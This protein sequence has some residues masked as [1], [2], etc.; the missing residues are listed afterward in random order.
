MS[1]GSSTDRGAGG[2]ATSETT[3]FSGSQ[4]PSPEPPKPTIGD[5]GSS[6]ATAY[7]LLRKIGEGGMG[8]V[9]EAEQTRPVRRRLAVK[10]IKR[11]MDTEGVVRRFEAERQALALMDHPGIAKVFDAGATERGRPFFAMELVRGEPITEYCDKNRLDLDARLRLFC[12]VCDAVQHAHQKAVIHRD[13]KPSNV[14]VSDQGGVPAPKI[15]DFGV[16]KATTQP[17]TE[18]TLYTQIGQVIGTP[19][20]MSPE[21]AEMSSADID[22]RS[23]VYSLGVILYVLMTGLLPFDAHRLHSVSIDEMRRI[24]RDE[25]PPT[26]S[27]MLRR[28]RSSSTTTGDRRAG[29]ERLPRELAG[30][31]D[32]IVMKALE[33]DRARRYG[34]AREFAA[35]IE[36]HLEHIPVLARPITVRYRMAKFVRRHWGGVLIGSSLLFALIAFATFSGYQAKRIATERDRAN[37]QAAIA[38]QVSRFLI[39]LFEVS[40]PNLAKGED[41]TARELL[42][43]GA[44]RIETELGDQPVVRAKLQ[45]TI[46]AVYESVGRFDRAIEMLRA[47]AAEQRRLLGSRHEETL[48]TLAALS[49][50]LYREGRYSEQEPIEF[51]LLEARIAKHGKA[52]VTVID[53]LNGVGSLRFDQGRT[54]EA[55]T[56][57]EQAAELT[58]S[59]HGT[60]SRQ[61]SDA[62]YNLGMINWQRGD[63][64]SAVSRMREAVRLG[65]ASLGRD[66]RTTITARSTLGVMLVESGQLPEAE[67]LLRQALADRRRMLGE[68]HDGTLISVGY[69]H[70]LQ[71]E[72]GRFEEALTGLE[73][74]IETRLRVSPPTHP[75]TVAAFR[76]AAG[77]LTRME[78]VE[79]AESLLE[80]A[81]RQD[82]RLFS[83][84][85]PGML[86]IRL[87][88]AKLMLV[89]KEYEAAR[90]A[91]VALAET[92]VTR[93]D[94]RMEFAN[95]LI[96]QAEALLALQRPDEAMEA[97]DRAKTLLAGRLQPGHPLPAEIDGLLGTTLLAKGDL[98]AARTL[99]IDSHNR[100]AAISGLDP[101]KVAAA[102]RRVA[103]FHAARGEEGEAEAW[104]QR[105]ATAAP[106]NTRCEKAAPLL[107]LTGRWSRS[108][109]DGEAAASPAG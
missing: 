57:Y 36:R 78:C 70:W 100:L 10:V 26:P 80:A 84:D 86:A 96:L 15:I 2:P 103:A 12:R 13:L 109:G 82:A 64:V 108:L 7:K 101:R 87:D 45:A 79:E 90:S 32:W 62:E 25:D 107:E 88:Q 99:L 66:D 74:L 71:R 73:A 18:H 106:A 33:K 67:A 48:A 59:L 105:A 85:H 83:H 93:N 14:L 24:I 81:A 47:A 29:S 30:D 19:T 92:F 68:D 34:S 27:A 98:P 39:D 43:R 40:D 42:D 72:Q 53:S 11:G 104:R 56:Y 52:H 44:D 102:G 89:R 28:N 5:E 50:A 51:E 60:E 55:L 77:V 49:A 54:E 95:S 75:R 21:Q 3:L 58:R 94:S 4:E 16:A 8:E 41:T 76:Q 31:L 65:E 1:K 38:D 69:W 63:L 23:D 35:D 22:T 6:H 91:A 97:L 46:G 61:A 20:F 17:L 37:A 9:W